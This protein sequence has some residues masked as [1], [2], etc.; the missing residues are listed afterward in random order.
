MSREKTADSSLYAFG[1][2]KLSEIVATMGEEAATGFKCGFGQTRSWRVPPNWS[3]T[4]WREELCALAIMSAWQAIKDF[5]PSRGIP[6]GGFVCYRV[7]AQALTRYRQE[8]RYFLRN[9]PTDTEIIETLAGADP[10]AQVDCAKF[11]PLD[12]SLKQLSQRERWLLDQIF[13]QHRTESA[14]AAELHVSQQAISK[15]KRAALL[16]LRAL[17]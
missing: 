15:R 11:D 1:P 5:A 16:H 2:Y 13:W 14:I 12:Q 9:T 3:S 6:L 7:K 17:L 8:W 4:D 10:A